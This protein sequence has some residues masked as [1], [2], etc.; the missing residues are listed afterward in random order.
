[1]NAINDRQLASLEIREEICERAD[2][3]GLGL[4]KFMVSDVR[5]L[6]VDLSGIVAQAVEAES[7]SRGHL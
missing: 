1:M 6:T 7:A 2:R 3:M 4:V 5:E